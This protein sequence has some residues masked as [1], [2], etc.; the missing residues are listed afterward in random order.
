M[1]GKA[2]ALFLISVLVLDAYRM[3]GRDG[4]ILVALLL[5]LLLAI[6]RIAGALGPENRGRVLPGR[7]R[8]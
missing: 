4:A 7:W 3:W 8:R 2:I 6:P 1:M 5:S